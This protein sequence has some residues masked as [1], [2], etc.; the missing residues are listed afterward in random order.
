MGG[1][2]SKKYSES[3]LKYFKSHYTF[4]TLKSD[5]RTDRLEIYQKNDSEDLISKYSRVF[6][7]NETA[8]E[9]TFQLKSR[10]EIEHSNILKIF[11]FKL[12]DR[13]E[14]CMNSS[15]CTV[16]E[17]AYKLSLKDEIY[18]RENRKDFFSEDELLFIAK[19][20]LEILVFT[21]ENGIY[22]GD[23]HPANIFITP[24]GVPK[25]SIS[26]VQFQGDVM[27]AVSRDTVSNIQF[28]PTP[29]TLDFNLDRASHQYFDPYKSDLF[30]LG[31]T[32]MNSGLLVNPIKTCFN[33]NTNKFSHEGMEILFESIKERY[34]RIEPLLRK[35]LPFAPYDRTPASTL[36]K[37][38]AAP[39]EKKPASHIQR[40]GSKNEEL[41]ANKTMERLSTPAKIQIPSR[42]TYPYEFS[43][44]KYPSSPFPEKSQ[45]YEQ[46]VQKNLS[47]PGFNYHQ[48]QPLRH[49][50]YNPSDMVNVNVGEFSKNR[51]EN[52]ETFTSN[53]YYGYYPE[54]TSPVRRQE[55]R[56]SR[57]FHE[58]ITHN[59][60]HF[61]VNQ[62]NQF[63]LSNSFVTDRVTIPVQQN[64]YQMPQMTQTQPKI[65]F[66][67]RS[68]QNIR[69]QISPQNSQQLNSFQPRNVMI[70][71]NA[72]NRLN[73]IDLDSMFDRALKTTKETLSK[74]NHNGR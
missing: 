17:E 12:T 11:G 7:D 59:P 26:N 70:N 22:H 39:G 29:E 36:L 69:F 73:N 15:K 34:P 5:C 61:Q 64:F 27:R 71:Q 21:E 20:M 1:Q 32:L 60:N 4:L 25:I 74:V 63:P 8:Q 45:N 42:P 52:A 68:P 66:N 47:S 46:Y 13:K 28:F 9:F 72:R 41:P 67:Q 51:L 40:S 2:S 50:V 49:T 57:D 62:P 30:A 43:S 38:F 33:P 65:S 6:M 44:P 19:V 3:T 56:V 58:T 10:S 23:I 14:L 24:S 53:R 35:M 37:H 54:V 18:T 48:Q 55:D 31:L 16:F